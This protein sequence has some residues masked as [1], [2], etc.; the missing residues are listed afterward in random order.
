MYGSRFSTL[1]YAVGGFPNGAYVAF[2]NVI[3]P[4]FLVSVFN[5]AAAIGFL[6]AVSTFEAAIAP[7]VVG[8][9][10]DRLQKR[11]IF[12]ALG[13]LLTI[14]FLVLLGF[15]KNTVFLGFLV[16]LS[17]LGR[18]I[19]IGP[20][21]A[22]LTSN[23]SESSRSQVAAFV[24]V[25]S[26]V[27]Q[28]VLT[29]LAFLLWKNMIPTIAFWVMAGLFLV[30]NLAVLLFSQD[31]AQ[32]TSEEEKMKVNIRGFFTQKNRLKYMLS[33]LFLWFGIN[34]VVPFLILFLKQ[35]L[36]FTQSQAILFYLLLILASGIF[37]YPFS[38]LGKKIS[39]KRA[40]I[41]GLLAFAA[42]SALGIFAEGLPQIVVYVLAF[43]AGIGTSAAAVFAFPLFTKLIPQ[44]NIGFGSGIHAF[45]TS[46]FA[47]LAA[48]FTGLLIDR[49]SYQVMFIVLV[50]CIG[51]C[52]SLLQS[53]DFENYDSQNWN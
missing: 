17:G 47:P 29:L 34:S 15:T 33:Q 14:V 3:L 30:P 39:D 46:G 35:Q 53:V 44:K 8:I 11:K 13:T 52:F 42:V 9:L 6:V 19:T 12:L 38:L 21:M 51:L 36:H 45:I 18:G 2:T 41:L 16:I 22:M 49:F 37:A 5:N 40:F 1:A 20:H 23:A 24:T 10:S 48:L 50:V 4:L 32:K 28:I 27:G 43:L 7:M 25:F 31:S 26:L